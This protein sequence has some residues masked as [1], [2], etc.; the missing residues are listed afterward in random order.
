MATL[1]G[2]DI[3]RPGT[4]RT[5]AKMAVGAIIRGAQLAAPSVGRGIVAGAPLA[6]RALT[7]SPVG[8][9][10][11]VG[12]GALQTEPGQML[13][14][15]AREKGRADRDAFDAMLRTGEEFIRSP[16]GQGQIKTKAKKAVSKYNKAVR[17][18]MKA[19]KSSKFAGKK[20]VINNPKT[21][22]GTVN[23]VVSALN[24]KKK[25]VPKGI[26]GTIARAARKALK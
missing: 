5:A 10:A 22:F 11:A 14:E 20:G 1:I 23:K 13:L 8:T 12:L 2:L 26:R 25:V 21:V 17:A 7:Y 3:I 9:G 19:V 24:K 6:Q 15:S 18:G 4:S 16:T